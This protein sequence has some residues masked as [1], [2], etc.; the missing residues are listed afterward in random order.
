[1][2]DSRSELESSRSNPS[3]G[4]SSPPPTPPPPSHSLV[5]MA[6][7]YPA[8]P[9]ALFVPVNQ[10]DDIMFSRETSSIPTLDDRSANG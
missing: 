9:K 3:E 10:D 8:P 7:A 2:I 5:S 1:M 4:V 6:M